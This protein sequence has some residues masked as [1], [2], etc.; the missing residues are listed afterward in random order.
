MEE[1]QNRC[2]APRLFTRIRELIA[3]ELVSGGGQGWPSEGP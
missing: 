1:Q 3:Y 2:L